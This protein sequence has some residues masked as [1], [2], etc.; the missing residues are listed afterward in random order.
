MKKSNIFLVIILGVAVAIVVST[1]NNTSKYVD[2][3]EAS[4]MAAVGSNQKVH[5][6]GVLKRDQN[7]EPVGLEYDPIKDP[8]TMRF[9]LVDEKGASHQ[10]VSNPPTSMQDFLKSEKV[11]IE[12]RMRDGQ[13][14]ASEILLK[15]PSKYE[16]DE[17]KS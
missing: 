1:A 5:I 14:V 3:A 7:N 12:G 4:S 8:N 16:E 11:V 10:V 13:F 2:F 15:C 9:V 6:I 17:L